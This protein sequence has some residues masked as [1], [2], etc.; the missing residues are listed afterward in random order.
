MRRRAPRKY[1]KMTICSHPSD[2]GVFCGQGLLLRSCNRQRISL[3]FD[4]DSNRNRSTNSL[5]TTPTA[6]QAI[7]QLA[8]AL[9]LEAIDGA[10]YV[11][12][13]AGAVRQSVAE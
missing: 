7:Q 6:L 1:S 3:G 13:H 10:W 12:L 11:L 9:G 8:Q 4:A 5:L 2:L